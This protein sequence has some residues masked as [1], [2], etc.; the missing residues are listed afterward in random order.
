MCVEHPASSAAPARECARGGRDHSYV[1]HAAA[2][3]RRQLRLFGG[4]P[5]AWRSLSQRVNRNAPNPAKTIATTLMPAVS[6][7]DRDAWPTAAHRPAP[8]IRTATSA[9][10]TSSTKSPTGFRSLSHSGIAGPR[11][12]SCATQLMYWSRP[13]RAARASRYA[14]CAHGESRPLMGFGSLDRPARAGG[15]R[16]RMTLDL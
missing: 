7:G 2:E 4:S 15:K 3:R 14:C 6:S 16:R 11:P 9:G 5:D 13:P 8:A 12:A 10:T 1:T